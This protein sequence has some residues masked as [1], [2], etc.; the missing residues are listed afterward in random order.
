MRNSVS[1]KNSYAE[2]EASGD[3]KA[4]IVEG[5][6][7]EGGIINVSVCGA[8]LD[9]LDTHDQAVPDN[10]MF[11]T[12]VSLSPLPYFFFVSINIPYWTLQIKQN[13]TLQDRVYHLSPWRSYLPANAISNA[14]AHNLA[15]LIIHHLF[16]LCPS[17]HNL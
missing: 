3:G 4:D 12:V 11:S 7:V 17:R 8:Q 9:G 15:N 1:G 13:T 10:L 6:F 14:L 16:C 5:H 2:R